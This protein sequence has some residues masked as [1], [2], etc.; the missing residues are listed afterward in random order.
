LRAYSS[1]TNDE[2]TDPYIRQEAQI[3]TLGLL[4]WLLRW[5]GTRR[6][7]RDKCQG[8]AILEA[9][10][11]KAIPLC[12]WRVGRLMD[13]CDECQYE[14]IDAD[15]AYCHHLDY[16]LRNLRGGQRLAW[17][18]QPLIDLVYECTLVD[19]ESCRAV[20]E[21]VVKDLAHCIDDSIPELGLSSDVRNLAHVAGPSKRRRI[22][23]DFR[24]LVGTGLLMQK[25]VRC[26]S[27][28]L[29]A[30]TPIDERCARWWELESV[31]QDLAVNRR[32]LTCQGVTMI[33]EDASR[34]GRPAEETMVYLLWD[35]KQRLAS[36]LPNMVPPPLSFEALMSNSCPFI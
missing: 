12:Q 32:T 17:G 16:V 29:R 31:C 18:W 24:Q 14:C 23:E 33:M 6:S 9:L 13:F 8:R 34:N 27:Q 28:F 25:K 21:C 20:S 2:V 35:A 30:A 22:D 7:H 1:R 26:G 10:F 36:A 3:S 4:A 5:I 15:G 11:A 19:C